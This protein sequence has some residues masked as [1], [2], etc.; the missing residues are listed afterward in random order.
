MQFLT[1][2]SVFSALSGISSAAATNQKRSSGLLFSPPGFAPLPRPNELRP[3]PLVSGG[4]PS[5]NLSNIQG[6][7]L[8][9]MTKQFELFYFFGISSPSDFKTRLASGVYPLITSTLQI[10]ENPASA[11]N[12]AFSNAGFGTLGI[13][14]FTDP[15]DPFAQGQA[16]N[17]AT[18]G[19]PQP[20]QNNWEPVFVNTA[21][22]HGVLIIT[23]DDIATINST[24]AQVTTALGDSIVELYS[25]QAQVRP[26]DEEGH[27]HFGFLDGISQPGVEGFTTN[28]VNGQVVVPAGIILA[29]EDGDPT[30]DRPAWALDGSF[31]AFRQ[32]EQLVPEF[33]AFLLDNAVFVT[34]IN[35]TEEG[36]E[37]LGARMMG[38]WKSGTPV[39]LSPLQDNLTISSNPNLINDFNFTLAGDNSLCPFAAH[40][41]KTN[42]RSDLPETVDDAHRIIRGGTPYGPEVTPAEAASNTTTIPR[43]LAFVAYQS[44]IAN[45]FQFLQHTWANNPGF[46]PHTNFPEPGFDAIIGANEGQARFTQGLDPANQTRNITLPFDFIISRGG[47]YFFSPSLSAI[48][49]T[50]AA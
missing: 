19:D 32:L 3:T 43:G 24:L 10:L 47:E 40:I 6:D 48:I 29:G 12:I 28:P 2:L 39:E 14:N 34:G 33:D 8:V 44:N 18:L 25:L 42:P 45:G 9:G 31:L 46:L 38:R 26:G 17:A 35:T 22:L 1:L 37:L 41:R 27:E 49:N 7:I 16:S 15:T 20:I 23:A 21:S 30:T 11:V 13:T 36:A 4:S 50:I 5:L